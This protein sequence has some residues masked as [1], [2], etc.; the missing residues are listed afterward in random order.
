MD[1]NKAIINL[2]V[3]RFPYGFSVDPRLVVPLGTNVFSE[4]I[5]VL[6]LRESEIREYRQAILFYQNRSSYLRALAL[7]KRRRTLWGDVYP[8]PIPPVDREKARSELI[9]R[10]QWSEKWEHI[11]RSKLGHWIKFEPTEAKRKSHESRKARWVE[12]LHAAGFSDRDIALIQQNDI[13]TEN[14]EE[15]KRALNKIECA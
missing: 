13:S 2:L 7:G 6:Q 10:K 15:T 11:Y 8:Q 9:R 4:V 1:R 5:R 3:Q 12:E 14:L